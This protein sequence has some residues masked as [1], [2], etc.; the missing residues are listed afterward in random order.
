VSSAGTVTPAPRRGETRPPERVLLLSESIGL[1]AILGRLLPG[2]DRFARAGSLREAAER[3][4]LAGADAVVLDAPPNGR[5]GA[6]EQLR[7]DYQGPLVVL[8]EPGAAAGD[9]LQ[10][11]AATLLARP[12]A[13]E[14]LGAALGLPPPASQGDV[15]PVA[16]PDQG[17]PPPAG[18]G[19][20]DRDMAA[21]LDRVVAARLA[22]ARR[23][24]G[25]LADPPD[26][27]AWSRLRH[28]LEAVPEELVHAWRARRWVRMAGFW[29][30][31]LLAFLIAFVVAARHHGLGA[32]DVTPPPTVEADFPAAPTTTV[33]PPST[34]AGRAGTPGTS[35]FRGTYITSTTTAARVTTTT[36]R[37]VPGGGGTT[38]TSTTRRAT[39][40]TTGQATTTTNDQS[41]TT[42]T[43]TDTTLTGP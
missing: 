2:G 6:V 29:G 9:L 23:P 43:T 10:D 15:G 19:L 18:D 24:G 22:A 33:R 7:R 28:R 27:S 31:C 42:T 3:G 39:T 32:V 25:W 20:G 5:L 40:T 38:R 8:V 41:T 21:A 37:V 34:S 1:A 11:E 16:Q 4:G 13:A 14:D 26:R 36:V 17:D 30:V 35:G 12:F